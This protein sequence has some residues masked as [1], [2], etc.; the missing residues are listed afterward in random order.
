MTEV[1]NAIAADIQVQRCALFTHRRKHF[2][3][4]DVVGGHA[5][6][7]Q[8]GVSAVQRTPA[9]GNGLGNYPLPVATH[10]TFSF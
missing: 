6:Q 4:G 3:E 7:P 1:A 10:I 8:G 9:L 2:D 5:H